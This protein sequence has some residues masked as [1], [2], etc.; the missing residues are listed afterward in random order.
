MNVGRLFYKSLIYLSALAITGCFQIVYDETNPPIQLSSQFDSVAAKKLLVDGT[1]T[2][3]GNAIVRPQGGGVV[4]CAG[5]KVSLVPVTDY[6]TER[7]RHIYKSDQRGY[8]SPPLPNF[9]CEP[10]TPEYH[11]Q[12]K[13]QV[14]DAQGNFAFENVADGEFYLT[15]TVVWMVEYKWNGGYLMQRVKLSGGENRKIVLT[16]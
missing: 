10:N 5:S 3:Q 14:C 12:Q 9:L 15:A 2:I 8:Y 13:T 1:N 11:T 7:M 4:T 6:A 16:P